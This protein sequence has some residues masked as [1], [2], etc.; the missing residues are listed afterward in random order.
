MK[1][2][3]EV[4]DKKKYK[5]GLYG[6]LTVMSILITESQVKELTRLKDLL[7]QNSAWLCADNH[8]LRLFSTQFVYM[9]HAMIKRKK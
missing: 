6:H 3:S 5:S 4:R 2:E 7:Q 8:Y 1:R 9:T